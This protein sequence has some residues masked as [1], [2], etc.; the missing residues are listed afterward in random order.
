MAALVL[1]DRVT[2]DGSLSGARIDRL[3]VAVNDTM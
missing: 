3:A 1:R 2:L